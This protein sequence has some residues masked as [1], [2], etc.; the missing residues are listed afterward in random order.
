M[1]EKI[2]EPTENDNI[3]CHLQQQGMGTLLCRAANKS[4]RNST[5]EVNPKICFNCDVGKIYRDV[6]CDAVSPNINVYQ[7]AGGSTFSV[8][9]LFCQIRKRNTTLDY[10]VECDLVPA[11][12]TKQIV[13]ITR[14]LFK[15]NKFFS[16][17]Q[18]L[19]KAR[20]SFRDGNFDNAI[21][22][23]I[24]SLESTMKICH[25]ELNEPLPNKK[26]LTGLW[27]STRNL[28]SFDEI[29]SDGEI[30]HL[31]NALT[32]VTTHLGGLRNSLSDAHGKGTITPEVTESIAELSINTA[33]TLSTFII[34]RFNQ[35]KVLK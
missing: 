29:D 9:S 5:N 17:Y 20:E 6:G 18:D 16:A 7:Y 21:T 35:K 10:C 19:E 26:Q 25:D 28:L 11:E 3:D 4:S 15:G 12:T 2:I 32:G 14:G 13:T 24:A 23:S 1:G 31:I 22:R 30:T 33:S 27:K 34:R 8:R